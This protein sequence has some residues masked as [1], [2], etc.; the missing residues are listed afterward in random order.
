[1]TARLAL[2]LLCLG[3]CTMDNPESPQ[4][5]DL[6]FFRCRV[7]PVLVATCAFNACHGDPARPLRVY[8]PNR[9]RL[10]VPEAQRA[11]ALTEEEHDRNYE[12]AL[13]FAAPS[14]G[15]REGMLAQKPLA[16]E[17]GGAYHAGETLGPYGDV[18]TDP[19]DPDL[20]LLRDWARGAT[21]EP[22]CTP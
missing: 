18:F 1:V 13:V 7:E 11:L 9:L 15:Y 21:E 14:D 12:S 4:S 8:G 16:T 6:P 17:A 2:A 10:R 20:A 3:G 19:A 5:L 22:S